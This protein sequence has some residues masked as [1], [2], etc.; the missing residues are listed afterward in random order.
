V[1]EKIARLWTAGGEYLFHGRFVD[2]VGL[3]VSAPG[4]LAKA[5]RGARGVA[6]P[7]WNT[8]TEPV[9]FDLSVDL[10]LLGAPQPAAIRATSLGAGTRRPCQAS[11]G[12]VKVTVTLPAHE[13]DLLVLEPGATAQ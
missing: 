5:Y 2:D 8:G 1:V 3:A 10:E 7:V 13:I 9:T 6:V 11:G 4:V 12:R